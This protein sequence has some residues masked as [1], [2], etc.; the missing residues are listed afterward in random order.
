MAEFLNSTLQENCI[1]LIA[2]NDEYGKVV[3]G[4]IDPQ[5]FEGDYKVLATRI[6]GYWHQFGEA[7]KA[8]TAD[9]IADI[10]E[11][12]HNRKAQTYRRILN[13]MLALSE[14]VNTAYVVDQVRL[15]HRTQRIKDGILKSAEQINSKQQHA[16]G[17][18]EAIWNELLRAREIDFDPGI[19]GSEFDRVLKALAVQ[20]SEFRCGIKVLD[21]R[22]IVPY[23]GAVMLWLG[24]AGA[25]K[26]FALIHLGK[27][28]LLQRKKVLHITLEMSAEE[29]LQRYYQSMFAVPRRNAEVLIT[30]IQ[31]NDKNEVKGFEQTEAHPQFS[32]DSP[33]VRD[34]L[35]TRIN[36]RGTLFDNLIIKRF[37][38]RALSMDMLRGYL[39]NLEITEKFIPDMTV[40][41]YIGITKTDAKNHRIHLGRNAEEFRGICV[42]RH[43]VGVTAHQ[44]SKVGAEA[45]QSQSTHVSEDWSLIATHDQV[46][47]YSSTNAE[48]QYGLARLFVSKARSEEDKFGALITQQYATGQFCLDSAYLKS[49]YFDLLRDLTGDE[50]Q[51]DPIDD[52]E[53]E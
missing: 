24:A 45:I 27:H 7:P 19:R 46:V 21:D 11:D 14:Q 37:P 6:I 35:E 53:D 48:H 52:E 20:Q 17:E 47:T 12:P 49:E 5:L 8:H 39:D 25:G 31:R 34:E 50:E 22:N 28:A 2:H 16:I 36:L 30:S 44:I 29:V 32:F 38:P 9:L 41:D 18:V 43:Q 26:S 42:E 3:A 13:N 40:L 1:T 15:H 51:N 33:Y 4:L 10:L 23:R